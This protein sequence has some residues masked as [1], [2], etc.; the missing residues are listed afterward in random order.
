MPP[1]RP[2]SDRVAALRAEAIAAAQSRFASCVVVTQNIDT[3]HEAAGSR[4]VLH[5][6]GRDGEVRCMNCEKV[7]GS[8]IDLSPASVCPH[9]GAVGEPFMKR[10]TSFD[11]MS[12]LMRSATVVSIAVSYSG[13]EVCSAIACSAIDRASCVAALTR[14]DGGR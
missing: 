2:S 10:T 8:D 3:L 9:C 7:D 5:M 13:A 12:F 4:K 14:R 1:A 11:E 6:H